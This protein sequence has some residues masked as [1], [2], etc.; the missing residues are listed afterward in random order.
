MQRKF[1][2]TGTDTGVG[3]TVISTALL[4]A[5]NKHGLTTAAVKPVAAGCRQTA[6]GLRNDDALALQAIITQSLPYQQVN[7]I[8]VEPAIAPHI[9][10]QQAKQTV[11]IDDLITHCQTVLIMGAEFVVIEGAGG[12]RVPLNGAE[13]L[14][15]LPK[16][17]RLPTILIVGMRLGCLNHTLLTV[18]A[19]Q[20]DGIEIIGWVANQIEPEMP[21][22]RENVTS[23]KERLRIPCLGE[24]PFMRSPTPNAAA[25]YLNVEGLL[26]DE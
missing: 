20:R 2:V 6:K 4:A 22:Y 14:A 26:Q 1:F 5:A 16:K 13:T 7:P 18:E 15:D 24:V 19:M 3:K 10:L 17:M 11:T 9:A 23:L 12:W 8:A 25:R 21:F